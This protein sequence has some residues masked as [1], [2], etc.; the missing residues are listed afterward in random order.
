MV[1]GETVLEESR[2][3]K[4]SHILTQPS[5]CVAST[6]SHV[7]VQTMFIP[8]LITKEDLIEAH[9]YEPLMWLQ[10]EGLLAGSL[11]Q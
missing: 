3:F 7:A 11:L 1:T 2:L 8:K 5:S 4:E 9:S 6:A 10:V